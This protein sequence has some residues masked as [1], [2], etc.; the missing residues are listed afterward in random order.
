MGLGEKMGAKYVYTCRCGYESEVSGQ[1]DMGFAV[2]TQTMI[3]ADCKEVV[4]VVIGAPMPDIPLDDEIK[5]IIGKCST[6]KG[7]HVTKWPES[8]PCPKCN[9]SMEQGEMTILWD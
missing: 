2:R 5:D 1:E 9:S 3:C 8:Q 4:D 7:I 6:C